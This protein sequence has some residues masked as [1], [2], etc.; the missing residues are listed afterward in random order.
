MYRLNMQSKAFNSCMSQFKTSSTSGPT[1]VPDI[2]TPNASVSTPMYF[3]ASTLRKSSPKHPTIALSIPL[4]TR[5]KL[6]AHGSL[7][8]SPERAEI[9][10]ACQ[11]VIVPPPRGRYPSRLARRFFLQPTGSSGCSLPTDPKFSSS[12]CSALRGQS[13]SPGRMWQRLLEALGDAYLASSLVTMYHL[14]LHAAPL[15]LRSRIADGEGMG[16][17]A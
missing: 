14:P 10:H 12:S 7:R 15:G 3:P 4:N 13:H 6:R 11:G 17:S 5:F 16:F 9:K 2:A 1:S 8:G